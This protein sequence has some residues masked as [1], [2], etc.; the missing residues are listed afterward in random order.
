MLTETIMSITS[1]NVDLVTDV[2]CFT[3]LILFLLGVILRIFF[4]SNIIEAFPNIAVSL[5]IFG[6]FVGIFI[7]LYNFD[8]HNIDKSIPG[9][10]AGLKTAFITSIVGIFASVM[11]RLFYEGKQDFEERR[12]KYNDPIPVLN[13]ILVEINSIKTA[14]EQTRD[15]IIKCFKSD[16]E[17]S[18]VSQVKLIRQ[19]I[20]DARREVNKAFAEFAEKLT[21]VSTKSLVDAL[22]KVIGEFNVLLNELVGETFKD[23]SSAMVNINI[24][25]QNYKEHIDSLENKV[26]EL[27]KNT[28]SIFD[29]L[30]NLTANLGEI[31]NSLG[32]ISISIENISVD[33]ADLAKAVEHLSNQN[34]TL[35]ESIEQIRQVGQEAKSVIPEITSNINNLTS[36]LSESTETF[37]NNLENTTQKFV[38]INTNTINSLQNN[39]LESRNVLKESVKEFSE[40]LEMDLDKSLDSLASSLASLSEKFVKDYT[41]LTERLKNILEIAERSHAN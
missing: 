4:K 24:W 20:I 1:H 9:M 23:L 38:E 39:L 34:R 10:L 31:E 14:S 5:G 17:Y 41:P 28:E 29:K 16:E 7:G 22:H 12:I 3:I 26:S 30:S 33:G 11:M 6:T 35:S 21:E 37:S 32:Q 25:Q 36:K 27:A 19:E 40:H 13:E 15:A 18:L 8:V 2:I